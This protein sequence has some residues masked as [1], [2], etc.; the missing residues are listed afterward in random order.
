MLS[1]PKST[2]V[3][4]LFFSFLYVCVKDLKHSIKSYH[5]N[6]ENTWGKSFA[7]SERREQRRWSYSTL[8]EAKIQNFSSHQNQ[9]NFISAQ[10]SKSKQKV[11]GTKLKIKITPA[12]TDAGECWSPTAHTA[13]AVRG[14]LPQSE[15]LSALTLKIM[16]STREHHFEGR[17]RNL[18]TQLLAGLNLW[19]PISA[20]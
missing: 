1:Y 6:Q 11:K 8:W 17:E 5:H 15:Q 12:V 13:S 16:E 4:Y 3:S 18:K 9:H 10:C 20:P 14:F 7:P 2:I 19:I